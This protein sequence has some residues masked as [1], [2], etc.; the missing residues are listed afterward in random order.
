MKTKQLVILA[1]IIALNVVI[2]RIFLIPVAFTHGNI[3]LSDA[4][5]VVAGLLF[6]LRSG[7]LVGGLSGFLLDLISG[8]PQYL[9][10]SLVIHGAQ[11]AVLGTAR[12]KD[13]KYRFLA[14]SLAIVILVSGYFV[15]DTLLYGL[16]V[17]GL[18]LATNLV[19]G[20][21]GTSLGFF[22]APRLAKLS[23]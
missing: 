16:S 14:G 8:Y 23:A 2:A 5:I 18:G 13:R 6:G 9:L 1:L 7:A 20:I 19:Q 10:F 11:G 15:A 3:N 22:L 17:G 4:G 12:K 21:A